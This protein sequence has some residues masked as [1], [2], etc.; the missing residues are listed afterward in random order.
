MAGRAA[1]AASSR[2]QNSHGR[3]RCAKRAA[4]TG[5]P[6]GTATYLLEYLIALNVR[7]G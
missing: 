1:W 7:H 4:R 3:R 5:S 6:D 2:F